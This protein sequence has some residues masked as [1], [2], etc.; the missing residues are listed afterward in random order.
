MT[1]DGPGEN[2]VRTLSSATSR[3]PAAADIITAP[4]NV[5]YLI[6]E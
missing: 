2:I 3:S 4:F 5:T 6:S 1:V